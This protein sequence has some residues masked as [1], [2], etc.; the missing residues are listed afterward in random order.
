MTG[1]QGVPVRLS[2]TRIDLTDPRTPGA[3]LL[4]VEETADVAQER[5]RAWAL[6]RGF[7]RLTSAIEEVFAGPAPESGYTFIINKPHSL[8]LLVTWPWAQMDQA[9]RP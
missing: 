7:D 3:L 8:L 2:V 4:D 9:A 6:V 1:H 5:A